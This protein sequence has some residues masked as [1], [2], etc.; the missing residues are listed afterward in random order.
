MQVETCESVRYVLVGVAF[1]VRLRLH[2]RF[3]HVC[4]SSSVKFGW[5]FWTRPDICLTPNLLCGSKCIPEE[6]YEQSKYTSHSS[7]HIS[8]LH[9]PSLWLFSVWHVSWARWGFLLIYLFLQWTFSLYMSSFLMKPSLGILSILWQGV[10]WGFIS[11][12]MKNHSPLSRNLSLL[13]SVWI[14]LPILVL[15]RLVN[16]LSL[17]SCWLFFVSTS[18]IFKYLSCR[19]EES[20]TWY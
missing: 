20:W 2:C 4:G 10:P 6:K 3:L 18:I 13:A 14:P 8:P 9:S 7:R 16:S 12:C 15:E 17:S 1:R 19:L 11:L 5:Q